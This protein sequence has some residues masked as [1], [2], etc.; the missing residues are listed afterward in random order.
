MPKS[1]SPPL[2]CPPR[3]LKAKPSPGGSSESFWPAGLSM[4]I[5]PA[6]V[7]KMA[8]V[9]GRSARFSRN[10]RSQRNS[11]S[12][13]MLRGKSFIVRCWPY[14]PRDEL[15]FSWFPCALTGAGT[16]RSNS[17]NPAKSK[18]LSGMSDYLRF[19]RL[20]RCREHLISSGHFPRGGDAAQCNPKQ[21]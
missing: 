18:R 5:I 8:A 1:V 7:P 16:I 9:Q 6:A 12:R 11:W 3:R 14:A 13:R 21:P 20:S 19:L 15:F 10:G 17:V 2:S 4:A